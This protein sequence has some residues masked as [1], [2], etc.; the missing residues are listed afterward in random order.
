[1]DLCESEEPAFASLREETERLAPYAVEIRYP[2]NLPEITLDEAQR[3][4]ADAEAVWDFV[5]AI[6]PPDFTVI[7]TAE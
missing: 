5:L 4:V 1:M 6:L 7:T 2:G 3:A